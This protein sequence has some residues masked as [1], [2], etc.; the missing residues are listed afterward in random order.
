MHWESDYTKKNKFRDAREK[1]N[2]KERIEDDM[3]DLLSQYCRV[4]NSQFKKVPSWTK[5]TKL[6][7]FYKQLETLAFVQNGKVTMD[8]DDKEMHAKLI[9]KS[10]SI[11]L[12]SQEMDVSK[13][14]MLSL[15]SSFDV[16]Y[17]DTVNEDLQ[18]CVEES[19]CDR[20]YIKDK[21]VN[22]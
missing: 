5:R 15:L 13:E 1:N 8:I 6:L 10:K 4:W 2:N 21:K 7:Y 17:F 11:S 9:Y 18:I 12:L 14:I 3:F 16:I 20:V 19:L 22:Q